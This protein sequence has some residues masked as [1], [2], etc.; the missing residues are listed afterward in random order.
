MYSS[1]TCSSLILL[2]VKQIW[3]IKP[4][5]TWSLQVTSKGETNCEG[6]INLID[7]T[8]LLRAQGAFQALNEGQYS[9]DIKLI[10]QEDARQIIKNIS[11]ID[12]GNRSLSVLDAGGVNTEYIKPLLKEEDKYTN[13]ELDENFSGLETLLGDICICKKL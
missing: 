9:Q 3:R 6:V 7:L 12:K 2:R 8:R 11:C 1:Y 4:I 5:G 13:L 10:K